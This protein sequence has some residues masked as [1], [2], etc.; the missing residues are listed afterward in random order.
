[1][2]VLALGSALSAKEGFYAVKFHV[3]FKRR[4]Q[5]LD[6]CIRM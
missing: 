4:Q 5:F 3:K 6:F 1:M 2:M